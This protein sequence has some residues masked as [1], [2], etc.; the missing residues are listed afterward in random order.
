MMTFDAVDVFPE[1]LTELEGW[2]DYISDFGED[3][4][5]PL[6]SYV[7]NVTGMYRVTDIDDLPTANDFRD[8]YCGEWDSVEDY[9]IEFLENVD[10]FASASEF[11]RSFF[12]YEKYARDLSYSLHITDAP[13]LS[14]WIYQ[15]R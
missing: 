3:E 4:Y 13:G 2:E 8:V 9:A 7:E 11:M 14:V 10:E 15:A 1:C 5:G 12:D 6:L